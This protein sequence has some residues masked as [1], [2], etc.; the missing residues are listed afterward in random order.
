[1]FVQFVAKNPHHEQV[2]ILNHGGEYCCVRAAGFFKIPLIVA[3]DGLSGLSILTI[4]R[5]MPNSNFK[6]MRTTLLNRLPAEL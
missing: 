1:M 2:S 6:L 5:L 3:A 4:Q